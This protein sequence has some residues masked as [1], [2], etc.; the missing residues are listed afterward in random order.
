MVHYTCSSMSKSTSST[1]CQISPPV[2][3][4]SSCAPARLH[5][6]PRHY[7][8]LICILQTRQATVISTKLLPAA[9]RA[10]AYALGQLEPRGTLFTVPTD[11]VYEGM[12]VGE[13][14]RDA[15]LDVN[16]V[17]EKKLSNV[18]NTG[19]EDRVTLSPP[20]YLLL[21]SC[22]LMGAIA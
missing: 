9:G 22:P 10:T 8:S 7:S 15:D 11:E 14:A 17:R 4:V 13:H 19:S 6:T 3:P 18:R 1:A 16:P 12:I 2:L 20:R 5:R 21:N